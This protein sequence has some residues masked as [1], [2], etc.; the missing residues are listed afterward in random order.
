[1]ESVWILKLGLSFL[2]KNISNTKQSNLLWHFLKAVNWFSLKRLLLPWASKK[3]LPIA[4]LVDISYISK[5]THFQSHTDKRYKDSLLQ[6]VFLLK[7][8]WP[9]MRFVSSYAILAI[10]LPL[11]CNQFSWARNWGKTL[12]P[13]KSSRQFLISSVL[14]TIFHVICAMQIMSGTQPETFINALLSTKIRQSVDIS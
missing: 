5:V 9:L 1:M 4:E 7:S 10:R 3:C 14:C 2:M 6:T 11:L 12:D 13:K 8:K